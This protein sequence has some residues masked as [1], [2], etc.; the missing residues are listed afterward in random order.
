MRR[1]WA[2]AAG[3]S[4]GVGWPVASRDPSA[5]SPRVMARVWRRRR[6]GLGLARRGS[7]TRSRPGR[8]L[9]RCGG[10]GVVVKL[11]VVLRGGKHFEGFLGI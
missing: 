11:D 2:G 5:R 9:G 1:P 6:N 8:P 7:P 3:S 10:H 4:D